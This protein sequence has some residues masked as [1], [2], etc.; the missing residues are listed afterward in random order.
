MP[1]KYHRD[2]IEMPFRK[3][4]AG[5]FP[6]QGKRTSILVAMIVAGILMAGLAIS[7]RNT[8]PFARQ[9]VLQGEALV[10]AK[11][12]LRAT[13]G[14][15]VYVLRLKVTL[16]DGRVAESN[17]DIEE[18]RW[19][20]LNTGERVSVAYKLSPDG[21]RVRLL[22]LNEVAPNVPVR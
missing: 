20:T 5:P 1:V 11:E 18:A 15:S 10:Q 9:P 16:S 6:S 22:R 21:A 19:N 13:D 3:W 17:L 2:D 12:V 4:V 8:D 14:S 7:I